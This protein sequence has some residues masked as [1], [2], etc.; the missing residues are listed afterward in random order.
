MHMILYRFID[1]KLTTYPLTHNIYL[2]HMLFPPISSIV[3]VS[4][5]SIVKLAFSARCPTILVFRIFVQN[6]PPSNLTKIIQTYVT[7]SNS[8]KTVIWSIFPVWTIAIVRWN[9]GL[10][11]RQYRRNRLRVLM[12]DILPRTNF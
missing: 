6:S 12:G 7:R 8:F 2:I 9:I 4:K 10:T 5:F 11:R 1:R 3:I